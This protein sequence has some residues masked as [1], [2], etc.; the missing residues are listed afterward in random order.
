M[1]QGLATRVLQTVVR[2]DSIALWLKLSARV[3]SVSYGLRR[4]SKPHNR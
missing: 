2:R 1:Q 4:L 3:R